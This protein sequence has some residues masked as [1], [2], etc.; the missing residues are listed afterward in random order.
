MRKV[1][2]TTSWDDGHKLDLKLSELLIKYSLTG[3]FYVAINQN[4]RLSDAEI[5]EISQKHEIGAHTMDHP[6]LSAVSPDKA[7]EEIKSSKT[8]LENIIGKSV[9]MFAY[10]FGDFSSETKKIV[11]SCGFKGARTTKDWFWDFPADV[12]EMP[13]SLHVYPHPL[14]PGATSIR[15]RLRPLFHNLP[16][17][18]QYRLR[19]MA[20]FSWKNLAKGVFDYAY[21]NGG[22]FHLWGHSW[23]IE[24]YG[25]WTDLE[26]F[27]KYI[28]RRENCVYLTN[29]DLL[30]KIKN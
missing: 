26:I 10:P 21:K 3:T 13:T 6:R 16:K 24:K 14:R 19:P 22:V 28:S 29:G 23:E 18:I 5:R 25:M 12:F 1:F 2:V 20:I 4:D 7:A 30:S 15:A 17:I 11:N 27:L 8:I 9:E